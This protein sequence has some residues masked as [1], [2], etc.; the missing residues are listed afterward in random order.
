MQELATSVLAVYRPQTGQKDSFDTIFR[1]QL[2]TGQYT[3]AKKSIA[4]VR[5]LS[6]DST[7][8]LLYKQ[9]ELF[10]EARLRQRQSGGSFGVHF[11]PI[12]T[13][14]FT[15]LDDRR[16][17]ILSTAFASRNGLLSLRNDLDK[18]LS[19]TKKDSLNLSEAIALCSRYTTYLVYQHVEPIARIVLKADDERRFIIADSVLIK[20]KEG[21]TL[22]AVV[23]R[24]RGITIP[25]PTALLYF[26][27]SNTDRSL[28]EAKYA[29]ARGYVGIVADTRGKRLSPD[30]V[31]PYEHEAKDVNSVIDWIVK[32]SWSNGKVGM[33][34]GS[35]SGFAQ[36]AAMKYP[37][38]ALKTIVPYVAAIP[39]QG[40]PMENNV[41]LNA[42]YQWAFYVTNNKYVDNEVNNDN[43]RW[44]SMRN[45][46]YESGAAYAKID[47][48]DG[49]PNPWL[50]RW[51]QH[52]A[53]DAYWQSM[54]PYGADFA[55]I[56]I[57]VLSITGYYDDG[58]ISAMQYVTEH[59][60]YKPNAEH[61]LIIGPYDHF[62]AQQGGIPVLRDYK[63][64]PI[65]LI[66]TKE[67]TFD[68]LDYVLKGGKKPDLLKD[69]INYEVMGANSWQHVPS[70]EK[71]SATSVKLY[72]TDQKE[73]NNYRLS[74][75][76]P[77]I[78]GTLKQEVDLADRSTANND[79]YPD[80]I[81][82]KELNRSNGLFFI[83]E[84]FA[85]AVSLSGMF[86][87]E[88]KA[89]TNKKDMDIGIVLYEVTPAGDYFELS[90]FLGR[91]SY[92]K[93]ASLRHLLKP[94][95]M[96]TIPFSKTRL[97]SRQVSKG[98]RLL[99][100][101]NIDKNPFAQINYGT[102][103]EVSHETIRDA[104]EPL[105]IKW[106]TDSFIQLPCQQNFVRF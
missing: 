42:N 20:T 100:V 90:Y 74:V 101:L 99:V 27:Y 63:V 85:H 93:D 37:H 51:L 7:A 22:S 11:T 70:I 104:G 79:Y 69:K 10:A 60:K 43:Q 83:S 17:L 95:V 49:T 38:P 92:A 68:W 40:L 6:K 2:V 67:I 106:S 54:V 57:P 82:R 86:S 3:E 48:I 84:P 80:P 47:S 88:L 34:G 19:G 75:Q 73:G 13:T 31:E 39:G 32:Q 16:A 89:V 81:I 14:L 41:F 91:A 56:T 25:Q 66:N 28:A 105:K 96:E 103:K 12:L 64:D 58:Q 35:Y 98:S 9:Y 65:A 8:S 53:Y 46:W 15:T 1:L 50:Q 21:A 24:K 59:Y 76:K 87:G 94:G 55:N 52:P 4:L 36:W 26:I 61:Y 71:M 78:P 72:L 97:F 102:G 45:R 62:G 77:K 5:S 29:A 44:R 33:Y 23:V 30:P 18:L